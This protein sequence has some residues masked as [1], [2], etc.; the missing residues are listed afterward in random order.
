[1]VEI[2][3]EMMEEIGMVVALG[4]GIVF[5]G[6]VCIV[7]LCVLMGKVVRLLEGMSKKPVADAAPAA[8]PAPVAAPA[9]AAAI[10]NRQELVAAIACCLAEE[11]G[12]DVSA[13]RIV[14]LK[15]V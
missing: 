4:V 11:L 8:A 10:P 2:S 6:L 1:M 12:T 13:I 9:V 14:S 3:A 5:A 15:K 7:I